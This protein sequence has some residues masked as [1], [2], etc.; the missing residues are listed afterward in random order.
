MYVTLRVLF[1]SMLFATAIPAQTSTLTV[2]SAAS[3]RAVIASDSLAAMFGTGL[4]RSTVSAT[5]DANGNLPTEL[6][7]TRVEFNGTAVALLFVSPTQINFVVPTGI[8]AGATTVTLVSTDTNTTRTTTAQVAASAPALFSSD[9]SGTGPGA[10]LNAVTFAPAP[11]VTVTPANGADTRTR[12]AAYGTGFRAAKN[13]TARAIDSFGNNYSLTVEFA[14]AAPGFF[15]L[16]QLNFIVPAGVD[17]A[18]AVTVTVATEDAV[19]N[20]VTFQMDLLPPSLLQLA[21]ITLSPTAVPAGDTIT[22]TVALTG[23]ART[24]GFP[25]S[26][27]SSNLAAQP[28]ALVTVPQGSS[29]LDVPIPTFSVGSAQIGVITAQAGL[30]TASA[31]FEVD[32]PNLVQLAAFTVFPVSNLGGRVLQATI[33]LSAPAPGGGVIVQITSDSLAAVPPPSVIVPFGQTSASFQIP[34]IAVDAPLTV[35]F[36]AVSNRTTLTTQVTLLPLLILAVDPNPVTGGSNAT[37][38]VTLADPA[39][40]AGVSIALTS[41]NTPAASVPPFITISAGR[42]SNTF[43]ITTGNV[44]SPQVVSISAL[45]QGRT[46]TVS[47]NVNPTP[48]PTLSSVTISPNQVTGGQS[49]QGAVTLAAPAPVGGI[50]VNLQSSALNVAQVPPIVTVQQG[51]TTAIFTIKTIPVPV[52]QTATITA[53]ANG[54][55]RSAVVT[56]Q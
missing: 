26:L 18:G 16:D 39:G 12:L 31:T 5:L 3:Y 14:G 56:V 41:T 4:A 2:V 7:S 27:R 9:A 48:Q 25:V 44:T 19:S 34:T 15:G 38:T 8:T 10:I 43:T 45:F 11:F 37:G 30:V 35:T 36:T 50:V 49:T 55:S 22:A 52:P 40:P 17:G 32:P 47:L 13:V 29:S 46:A 23:A 24:G 42:N 28:P 51:F 1:V 6:A 20:A 54:I 21:G 53:T 33:G